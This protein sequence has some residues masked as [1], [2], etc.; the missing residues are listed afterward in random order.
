VNEPRV[1]GH[2]KLLSGG[3][4]PGPQSTAVGREGR[5]SWVVHLAWVPVPVLLSVIGGL[6][7]A[8]DRTVME[9]PLLMVVLNVTFTWLASLCIAVLTA[10]AFLATGRP[11]FLMFGCGSIVWGLTSLVAAT[12]VEAVNFTITVHNLGVLGAALCHVAGVTWQGDVDRRRRRLAGGYAAAFA[13]SAAIPLAVAA[14]LT[15]VFFVQGEGGTAARHVVLFAA[16]LLFAGVSGRLLKDSERGSSAFPYW[17]GLGLALVATGLFGVMLLSVQGGLLGWANRLTQFTGSAYLLIAAVTSATRTQTGRPSLAAAS[18]ELLGI[19]AVPSS[20]P[21][22]LTALA[23]RYGSAIVVVAVAAVL[24]EWLLFRLGPGLPPYILFYPAV[25]IVALLGGAGP[26]ALATAVAALVAA[27]RFPPIDT[28]AVALTTDRLG[29][30]LFTGMGLTIGAMAELHRR[31][32]DKAMLFDRDAALRGLHELL[33]ALSDNSPDAIY[34]KDRDSRWLMANPAVLRIVGRTAT[35]ALGKTDVELYEDP[36]VGRAIVDNDRMVMERGESLTVEEVADTPDGRRVFLSTKAPWRDAQGRT[37]GLSG[38]SRDITA[39]KQA[40]ELLAR[41]KADAEQANRVKDDFL[42]V[43]SHELRTPLASMLGWAALLKGGKLD[44]AAAARAVDAIERG[45]RA[46]AHLIEDLLDVSRI[47]A[48]KMTVHLQ[49]AAANDLV[50]DAVESLRPV[51]ESK[52]VSLETVVGPAS[53]PIS[54]DGARI[55]QVIANLVGNAIKFTPEGGHV[56]VTLEDSGG[57]AVVAV[58]DDGRGI[59]REFLPHVF[60]RF[61]QGDTADRPR[62][63]LGLGLA[64]SQ[65]I[66]RLHDGAI[67]ADSDGEGKGATFRVRLPLAP[68]DKPSV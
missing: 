25:T 27:R 48:G 44:A 38:I 46:Q 5:A 11:G 63:G 58:Q 34:V 54:V 39:R 65:A 28:F 66:C 40:E 43:L 21:A 56:R 22:R 7:V 26:G 14:G 15:P 36:G 16:I 20:P 50:L 68:R 6:W 51:A 31:A 37:V 17:Y 3:P 8:D 24:R 62:S 32:R 53:V 45:A 19:W 67:T 12:R 47:V 55:H 4:A 29:L 41:A 35:D 9:S 49:P 30:A 10:R 57:E 2:D 1:S 33:R 18:N 52:G 60:D 23:L 64:I 42:A 13:A 61:S 59:S